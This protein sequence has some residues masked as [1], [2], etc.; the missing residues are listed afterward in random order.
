[1]TYPKPKV[2]VMFCYYSF[3]LLFLDC[4]QQDCIMKEFT[5]EIFSQKAYLLS[6]SSGH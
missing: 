2:S 1:M 6:S 3:Y 5:D 4:K